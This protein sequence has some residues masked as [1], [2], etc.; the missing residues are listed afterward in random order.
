MET[1]EMREIF[2]LTARRILSGHYPLLKL[3]LNRISE[4]DARHVMTK[5]L[6]E[7][8]LR[9]A[10]EVKTEELYPRFGAGEERRALVDLV[11]YETYG[12]CEVPIWVEFKRSL[13]GSQMIMKDF[14]KMM[15]EKK[16]SQAGF[17][18]ILPA[19]EKKRSNRKYGP[20]EAIFDKYRNAYKGAL[21]SLSKSM[22]KRECRPKQFFLFIYDFEKSKSYFLFEPNLCQIKG[23]EIPE[24]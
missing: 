19:P 15:I 22:D 23:F 24:P 21:D 6:E 2:N 20:I 10:L 3:D 18:H 1:Y 8:G 17:F 4:P 16:V 9:Y 11:I 12:G 5:V 7:K 14:I 13:P